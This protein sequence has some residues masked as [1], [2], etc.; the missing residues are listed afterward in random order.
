MIR[1]MMKQE[2]GRENYNDQENITDW[3][4]E[5]QT[6]K[7]QSKAK[8]HKIVRFVSLLESNMFVPKIEKHQKAPT[9]GRAR[10]VGNAGAAVPPRKGA[11]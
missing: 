4:V 1:Q 10:A 2:E 5:E 7:T 8:D 3:Q 9:L 11:T 6:K